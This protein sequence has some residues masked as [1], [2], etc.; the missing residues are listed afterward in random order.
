MY[1]TT[2]DGQVLRVTDMIERCFDIPEIHLQR[3]FSKGAWAE[4]ILGL[5]TTD[6]K[7][8]GKVAWV[9]YVFCALLVGAMAYVNHWPIWAVAVLAIDTIILTFLSF[10]PKISPA[11]Q[12]VFTMLFFFGTIFMTSVAEGTIYS[13]MFAFLGAAIILAVYLSGRL[14]LVYS[15]LVAGAVLFHVF[16]LGTVNFDNLIHI[17][18]FVVR[19]AVMFIGLLFLILFLAKMNQ[20]RRVMEESIREAQLAERYKSEF[21][22]NMSHEIRTPMNAI[23]GMCELILREEDLRDSVRENCFNIQSSGR[24]LLSIINDILDY[25]KID[26]GKMSLIIEEFNI[27]SVLNDVLNMSEARRG[28]KDIAIL[29]NVDPN[30]PHRAAWG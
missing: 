14:L 12:A 28:S 3:L 4:M 26:S 22:A 2:H 7:V 18:E 27:A 24:S 29:V 16:I 15:L 1:Y 13:T 5:I 17:I 10:A 9:I 20:S 6:R 19:V 25:S 11:I 21:L 23:I 8:A 30:I